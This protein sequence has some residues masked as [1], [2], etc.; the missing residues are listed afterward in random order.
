MPTPP[1][2]IIDDLVDIIEQL[3]TICQS[4]GDIPLTTYGYKKVRDTIQRAKEEVA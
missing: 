3:L 2:L 4:N 1:R